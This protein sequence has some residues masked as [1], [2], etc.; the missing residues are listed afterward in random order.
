MGIPPTNSNT[1]WILM[2]FPRLP[3]DFLRTLPDSLRYLNAFA[4]WCEYCH[5]GYDQA[6]AYLC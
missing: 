1:E 3:P 6:M 2:A 5:L 4:S